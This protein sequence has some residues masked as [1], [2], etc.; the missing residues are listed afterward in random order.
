MEIQGASSKHEAKLQL[1]M[2]VRHLGC[3][4]QHAMAGMEFLGGEGGRELC[5]M[6]GFNQ[7]QFMES[8]SSLIDLPLN[9]QGEW[10]ETFCR[11]VWCNSTPWQPPLSV[12]N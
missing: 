11:A 2:I 3:C 9:I 6:A 4:D 1:I 10:A 5:E 7:D 12:L 8:C